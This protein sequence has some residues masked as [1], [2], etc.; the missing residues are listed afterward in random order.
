MPAR[1]EL[2]EAL[3]ECWTGTGYTRDGATAMTT[4]QRGR[5]NRAVVEL[6]R[7]GAS[8]DEVKVKW[9]ACARQWPNV[10]IT[11]QTLCAHW[12]T[13]AQTTARSSTV[14]GWLANQ[15]RRHA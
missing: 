1:D 12:S 5:I 13:I 2:F 11:P 3:Y 6:K 10:T 9:K 8:P 7:I 15:R 4:T 14:D